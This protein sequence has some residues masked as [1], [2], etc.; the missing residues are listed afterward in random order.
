MVHLERELYSKL[1]ILLKYLIQF[2]TVCQ[3]WT[4]KRA[5]QVPV[6]SRSA[7]VVSYTCRE[8]SIACINRKSLGQSWEVRDSAAKEIWGDDILLDGQS[9]ILC[10]SWCPE[11]LHLNFSKILRML[12][13]LHLRCDVLCMEGY[14][15]T[16][17][18]VIFVAWVC[19]IWVCCI[20]F[21]QHM[22]HG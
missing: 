2:T 20:V 9:F 5:M 19:P 8:H 21:V 3:V 13:S 11:L 1:G 16:S 6:N 17:Q 10:I 4:S 15:I 22:W 12:Y 7:L 14:D 18:K